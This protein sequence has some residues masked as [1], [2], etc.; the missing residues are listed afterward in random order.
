M[1]NLDK[2][3]A[4]VFNRLID[5]DNEVI[6]SAVKALEDEDFLTACASVV[7]ALHS[8]QE[9][10]VKEGEDTVKLVAVAALLL[11]Y[12]EYKEK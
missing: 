10:G 9:E 3:L 4:N 1:N 12:N 7:S 5:G 2:E 6:M 11:N 8:I